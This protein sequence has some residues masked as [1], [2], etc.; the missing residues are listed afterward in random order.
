MSSFSFALHMENFSS[1]VSFSVSGG[2]GGDGFFWCF[3]S[4]FLTSPFPLP[5]GRVCQ[6][7]KCVLVSCD[8]SS[9]ARVS[10]HVEHARRAP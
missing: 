3:I 8:I 2:G 1:G 10:K 4:F 6:V 7:R 5:S 9:Q